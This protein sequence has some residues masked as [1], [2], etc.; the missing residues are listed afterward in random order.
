M[1]SPTPQN[2]QGDRH[3]PAGGRDPYGPGGPGDSGTGRQEA[4]AAIPPYVPP[5]VPG[6]SDP[7]PWWWAPP[8][9]ATAL[10]PVLA[11]TD[12][13]G[14]PNF[15]PPLALGCL[16]PLLLIV[17]AW[18]QKRTIGRRTRRRVLAGAACL[19]AYF[20]TEVVMAVLFG[21]VAVRLVFKIVSATV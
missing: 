6:P 17:T 13:T 8:A 19:L 12:L 2:P 11:Y 3:G 14:I 20:Y 16:L 9:L 15:P 21:V 7:D 18:L 10:A 4:P 1:S 5:A